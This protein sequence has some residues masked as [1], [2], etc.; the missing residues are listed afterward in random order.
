MKRFLKIGNTNVDL[1][2]QKIKDLEQGGR[3]WCLVACEIGSSKIHA[4]N[5][6]VIET[7]S[8]D[9]FISSLKDMLE[10]KFDSAKLLCGCSDEHGQLK[11]TIDRAPQDYVAELRLGIVGAN[12]DDW[13]GVTVNF[14]MNSD[15]IGNLSNQLVNL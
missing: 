9:G 4:S 6:S 12:T 2:I 8:I 14:S 1:T 7:L 3:K 11:L 15:Q 13:Y 10:N 5:F